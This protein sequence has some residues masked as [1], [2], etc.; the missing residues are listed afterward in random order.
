MCTYNTCA[1][2]FNFQTTITG[3]FI[4]SAS[5]STFKLYTHMLTLIH[6]EV[7]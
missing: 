5:K 2:Y 3:L 6:I 1:L 4:A 7:K